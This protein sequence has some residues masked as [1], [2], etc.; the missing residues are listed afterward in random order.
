MSEARYQRLQSIQFCVERFCRTRQ[1]GP[2]LSARH[3]KS[4]RGRLRP[5]F[6]AD[7]EEASK[8]ETDLY[9]LCRRQPSWPRLPCFGSYRRRVKAFEMFQ[10]PR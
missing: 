9:D 3:S 1:K 7:R 8:S 10:S 5:T 2:E 4:S 6:V